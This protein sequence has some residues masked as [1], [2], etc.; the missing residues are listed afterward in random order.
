MSIFVLR[1][2]EQLLPVFSHDTSITFGF[3]D[4]CAAFISLYSVSKTDVM[5]SKNSKASF[6]TPTSNCTSPQSIYWKN[7]SSVV[8]L[9]HTVHSTSPILFSVYIDFV[10]YQYAFPILKRYTDKIIADVRTKKEDSLTFRTPWMYI[11]T[12]IRTASIGL[13]RNKP[14][15]LDFPQKEKSKNGHACWGK[16]PNP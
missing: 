11:L 1:F 6:P 13:L 2:L 7:S 16:S 4:C 15:F 5:E 10:R 9:K 14:T 3:M 12:F 8:G